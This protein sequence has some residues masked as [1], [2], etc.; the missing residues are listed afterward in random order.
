[1]DFGPTTPPAPPPGCQNRPKNFFEPSLV[2]KRRRSIDGPNG[3]HTRS[4]GDRL[5]RSSDL[6]PVERRVRPHPPRAVSIGPPGGLVPPGGSYFYDRRH[7]AF[8]RLTG[9]VP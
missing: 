7:A 4:L 9:P 8:S 6:S 1:L 2:L 5:L 3:P